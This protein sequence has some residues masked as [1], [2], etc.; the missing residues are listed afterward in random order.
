MPKF[1]KIDLS[2]HAKKRLEEREIPDPNTLI[3]KHAGKKLRR[4]VRESCKTLGCK[5]CEAIYFGYYGL[6]VTYVFVCKQVDIGKFICLT[7]LK[8][9]KNDS[10]K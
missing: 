8:Y 2:N 4:K 5:T 10:N 7:A 1:P 6:N 9:L 3:L